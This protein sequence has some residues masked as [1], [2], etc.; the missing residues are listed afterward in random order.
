M[1][2]N[3]NDTQSS[4]DPFAVNPYAA[5]S[6]VG[7]ATQGAE[8]VEVYRR[9]YLQHEASVKSVG[10]LY[11]LSAMLLIFV[12]GLM[13]ALAF[14]GPGNG[15]QNPTPTVLIVVL[16]AVYLGL[17]LFQFFVA[18]GLRRFESWARIATVVLSI[19]GLLAFPIGTLISAYVLYLMLSEKGQIVF[20]DWYQQ[21]MERTPHIKYKTSI[22]VWVF[23]ALLASIVIVALIAAVGTA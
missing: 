15:G 9:Q 4:S 11:Y 10:M 17:G 1:S 7:S 2:N 16:G 21:V 13:A 14:A 5:T 23:V 8:D 6:N 20:S 3:P 22:I 12:G 19:I 18:R